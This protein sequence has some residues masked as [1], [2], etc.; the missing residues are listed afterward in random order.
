[1]RFTFDKAV[2]PASFTATDIAS[3]TGPNGSIS[4]TY[5]IAAVSGYGEQAV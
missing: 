3:F 4:T 1:M 2:D 5:T